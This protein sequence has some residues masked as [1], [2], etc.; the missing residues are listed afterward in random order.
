MLAFAQSG[1]DK[2][3]AWSGRLSTDD[4]KFEDRGA[5]DALVA[6]GK[7]ALIVGAHLG[8]LEMTRALAVTAGR[9]RITAIVYIEHAKRFNSVL[10]DTHRDF[11]MQL[12]H[13]TDFGPQ[14]AMMMQERIEAGELLVIVGDRVPARDAA[15]AARTTEA[16]FL[17]APARFAQGPYVLAHS[18]GCP[19]Y[20]FFCIK[21][22]GR[23]HLYFE[24]FAERILLPR[25]ERPERLRVYAQRYAGRLEYFCRKAPFQWFNFF[26]FWQRP[27]STDEGVADGRT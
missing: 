4:V 24:P 26:D 27:E 1:L 8:N 15:Q 13:V 22:Q 23:Y 2:I 3:A 7:G 19:V 21:E 16:V 10:A 5:F 6:S 11:G 12:V 20:L 25:G 9:A 17:G 18:L 14:T